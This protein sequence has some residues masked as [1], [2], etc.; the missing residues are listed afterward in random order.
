V[1]TGT[2]ISSASPR[3]QVDD[4]T[5]RGER[6]AQLSS[7]TD[8]FEEQGITALHLA[9]LGASP[10]LEDYLMSHLGLRTTPDPVHALQSMQR[11]TPCFIATARIW[12]EQRCMSQPSP[13]P[14]VESSSEPVASFGWSGPTVS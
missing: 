6:L 9:S 12:L 7:R 8:E 1:P 10:A 11:E 4:P 3:R 2:R 5:V 13:V 14:D